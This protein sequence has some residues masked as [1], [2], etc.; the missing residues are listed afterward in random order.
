M[1]KSI[2]VDVEHDASI[3]TAI[4]AESMDKAMDIETELADKLA[5]KIKANEGI[6]A[7]VE[8]SLESFGNE[9]ENI[10]VYNINIQFETEATVEFGNPSHDYYEEPEG[11]VV[12]ATEYDYRDIVDSAI[13][14]LGYEPDS[15]TIE[16][17]SDSEDRIYEKATD[18]KDSY[19]E[20][21]YGDF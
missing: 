8:V 5:D 12:D 19:D 3:S 1:G 4:E 6:D 18:L 11:D 14:D 15:D 20:P 2:T 13:K 21:E 17:N 7:N 10:A 16:I 9:E